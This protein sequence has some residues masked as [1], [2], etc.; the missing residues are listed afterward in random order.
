MG[1]DREVKAPLK[2]A[3]TIYKATWPLKNTVVLQIIQGPTVE[4]GYIYFCRNTKRKKKK[5]RLHKVVA[6]LLLLS[7]TR[8]L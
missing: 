6:A 4:V 8:K 3:Q 5:T 2:Y 7:E 1:G